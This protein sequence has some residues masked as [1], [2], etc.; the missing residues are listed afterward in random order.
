MI[1]TLYK[2]EYSLQFEL[3]PYKKFRDTPAVKFYDVTVEDSNA[4]DLVIHSGPAVSPPN[5][6]QGYWQFYMHSH[7]EDNL[8]ALQGGRTFFLVNF[9]W[10]HPFH[11]VRCEEDGDILRIPVGTFHRSVS[12]EDGSIVMNQAIRDEKFDVVKEFTPYKSVDIP[13]LFQLTCNPPIVH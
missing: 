9:D 4:R 8:L 6:A 12:D 10:E 2:T 5:D 7:Q 11:I 3:V 13:M 1:E